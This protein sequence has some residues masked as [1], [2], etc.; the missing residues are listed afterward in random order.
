MS[1]RSE[2]RNQAMLRD[3]GMCQWPPYCPLGPLEMAHVIP[4]GSGGKDTIDNV[5]MLCKWHHDMHDGRVPRKLRE[6]RMLWSAFLAL[7]HGYNQ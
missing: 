7:K 5:V 4:A 3:G 2:L 1:V 6:Y